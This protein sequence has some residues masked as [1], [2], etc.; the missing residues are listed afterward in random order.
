MTSTQLP[1]T[2]SYSF[3]LGSRENEYFKIYSNI[4]LETMVRYR[5]TILDLQFLNYFE[6]LWRYPIQIF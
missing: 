2:T 1:M 5:K 3:P 6:I 4:G